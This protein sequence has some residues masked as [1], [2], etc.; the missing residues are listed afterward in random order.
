[1]VAT[2]RLFFNHP[3]YEFLIE[4]LEPVCYLAVEME[5]IPLQSNESLR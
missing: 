4:A 5:E 2:P 1:M 3:G